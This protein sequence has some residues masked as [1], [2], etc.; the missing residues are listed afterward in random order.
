[1]FEYERIIPCKYKL[2]NEFQ[3]QGKKLELKISKMESIE[4]FNF[5]NSEY[6]IL[7]IEENKNSF[8]IHTNLGSFYLLPLKEEKEIFEFLYKFF[9]KMKFPILEGKI[10]NCFEDGFKTF[11]FN[12]EK[13]FHF[14]EI[15]DYEDKLEKLNNP[16]FFVQK[17]YKKN[18]FL[19][20]NLTLKKF[21]LSYDHFGRTRSIYLGKKIVS[22]FLSNFNFEK[23]PFFFEKLMFPKENNENFKFVINL[24]KE[25]FFKFEER[26]ILEIHNKNFLDFLDKIFIEIKLIEMNKKNPLED[27]E[28]NSLDILKNFTQKYFF[29]LSSLSLFNIMIGIVITIEQIAKFGFENFEKIKTKVVKKETNFNFENNYHFYFQNFFYLLQKFENLII[30][31]EDTLNYIKNITMGQYGSFQISSQNL[32]SE[33]NKKNDSKIINKLSSLNNINEE[34]EI[35]NNRKIDIKKNKENVD[36]DEKIENENDILNRKLDELFGIKIKK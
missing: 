36:N 26:S 30:K 11:F 25:D 5:L 33:K 20:E 4:S 24:K 2:N 17:Y 29:K 10:I 22:E 9:L 1:M 31:Y 7:K 6:N 18:E 8:L 21:F 15:F 35:I 14:S 27:C 28:I 32:D 13:Y 23:L 16:F 34:E 3:K 19:Y 12:F